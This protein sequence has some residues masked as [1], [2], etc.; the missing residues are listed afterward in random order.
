MA[1]DAHYHSKTA[2]SD[3]FALQLS[4]DSKNDGYS[5][6]AFIDKINTYGPSGTGLENISY[7]GED[8]RSQF[9]ASKIGKRTINVDPERTDQPL[10]DGILFI[11]NLKII[12]I[13]MNISITNMK[14]LKL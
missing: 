3:D 5:D 10:Q 7:N 8:I 1:V 4:D 11:C 2:S 14:S 9:S 12:Q 13:I 6:G